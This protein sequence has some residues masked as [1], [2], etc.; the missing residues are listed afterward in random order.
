MTEDGASIAAAPNS[1]EYLLGFLLGSRLQHIVD[2]FKRRLLALQ[3]IEFALER[4]SVCLGR[5]GV[6]LAG[7]APVTADGA[8][9]PVAIALWTR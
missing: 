2:L 1:S 4:L 9:R 8:N 7:G 5:I 6:E 3:L